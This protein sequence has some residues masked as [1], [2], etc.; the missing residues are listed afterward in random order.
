MLRLLEIITAFLLLFSFSLC[1]GYLYLHAEAATR[2]AP[3]PVYHC[4]YLCQ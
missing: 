4:S 2:Y 1:L 3:T